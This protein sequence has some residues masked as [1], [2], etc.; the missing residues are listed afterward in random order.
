[1]GRIKQPAP[2]ALGATTIVRLRS[3]LAKTFVV[4]DQNGQKDPPHW[5]SEPALPTR[6]CRFLRPLY[7]GRRV[8][9][10]IEGLLL[11][12]GQFHCSLLYRMH[13]ARQMAGKTASPTLG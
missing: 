9:G 10:A 2:G 3:S 1:L 6:L 12:G 8:R 4:K 13:Q 11:L 5:R 7:P